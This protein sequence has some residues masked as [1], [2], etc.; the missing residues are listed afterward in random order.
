MKIL[1]TVHQFFP[2]HGSGTEVLTLETARCLRAAGHEVRILTGAYSPDP[3]PA[4]AELDRYRHEDFDLWR[5]TVAPEAN[6]I[7][8]DY[9]NPRMAELF[10]AI[11]DEFQPDVVHVFHLMRLS[12]SILDVCH[13]RGL[14][15]VFTPT[16]FWFACP[17]VQLLLPD[18]SPC[19]GPDEGAINCVQHYMSLGAGQSRAARVLKRLP[20]PL[21][22]LAVRGMLARPALA[23]RLPAAVRRAFDNAQALAVRPEFLRARLAKMARVLVP[24]RFMGEILQRHGLRAEAA[25]YLPYGINQTMLAGIAHKPSPTFRIGYIGTLSP[26]KGAHVLIDAVRHVLPREL[27]VEVNI[28]GNIKEFPSYVEWLQQL[29]KDDERIRFRGTFKNQDIGHVFAELDVLVVP[30]IWYENT[31]LVIY[32]AQACQCPVIASDFPGMSEA[33]TDGDNG[34]LFPAEDWYALGQKLLT[35]QADEGLRAQLRSRARPPATIEQ[36]AALALAVYGEVLESTPA[37]ASS[38]S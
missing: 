1:L 19:Q 32:T 3:L 13:A 2:Q 12:A 26:H 21:T 28:Y 14:P 6:A 7:A 4:G 9:A 23:Q 38:P 10:A 15:V 22:R 36:Y 29:A 33:I 30:S 18:H 35:L 16:D 24:T 31:P 34:H 20:A 11:L 8:L 37:K 5:I 27:D 25:E 17:L